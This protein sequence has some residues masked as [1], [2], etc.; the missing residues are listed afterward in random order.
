MVLEKLS[1]QADKPV[2]SVEFNPWMV[3]GV[4]KITAN[5]FDEIAAKLSHDGKDKDAKRRAAKWQRYA[6]YLEYGSNA[7]GILNIAAGA[8]GVSVFGPVEAGLR[9]TKEMA[10]ARGEALGKQE[11]SLQVLRSE[12]RS[13]FATLTAPMLVVIDDIDRLTKMKSALSFGWLKRTRTFRT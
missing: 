1:K 5:F 6:R 7:L 8:A 2:T 10:K 13:D 9:K 11:K 12:L 4:E 3:S